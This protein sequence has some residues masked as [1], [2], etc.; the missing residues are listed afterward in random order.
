[1]ESGLGNV[2]EDDIQNIVERS[3][4]VLRELGGSTVLVTGAT[5]MI[6]S[7]AVR[8]LACANRLKGANIGVVAFVRDEEKARRV[9]GDA[10]LKCGVELAVGDITQKLRLTQRADYIIHG[11]NATASKSYVTQP[12]ETIKTILLGTANVLDYAAREGAKGV[13]YLSSMEV[14]GQFEMMSEDAV[15]ARLG[16]LDILDARSSY[17]EAKRAAECLCAA[18]AA[19]Y[20]APVRIARLARVIGPGIVDANDT[21]VL[22]E[23]ARCIAERRDI[24]LRTSGRTRLN[25][26]Y[27]TDAL[28]A[29]FLLLR[30][31]A[32]GEAYNVANSRG[33]MT[34]KEIAEAVAA[35]HAQSGVRVRHDIPQDPKEFGYNKE[36]TFLLN[37]E[38]IRALGCEFTVGIEEAI[39][40]TARSLM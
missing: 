17:P 10:A 34:V 11:A 6:G 22:T 21:R 13:V 35:R 19:E 30:K 7:L 15:E 3:A 37:N 4:P 27:T 8:A 1:M 16:S 14:Y 26:C 23:F 28:A 29:I 33:I 39:E 32:S 31:G 20:G 40:R 38:K 2:L 18:Y 25:Y 36:S 5:G 24:V 12:A 9:I